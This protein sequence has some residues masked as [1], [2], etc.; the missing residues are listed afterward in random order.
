MGKFYIKT[1]GCQMNVC[2]S[3]KMAGI[4]HSLGYDRAGT[5]EQADVVIVNTCSVRAKPD[6][7][8]Y[9]FIGS[10]RALKKKN[11]AT[12]VAV[13]GCIPQKEG[14]KLLRFSHVDL[15][16]GT[17]NFARL[18]ELIER[19]RRERVV[20]VLSSRLQRRGN[21]PLWTATLKTP[22]LRML[23]CKGVATGFALT[24]SFHTQG[25]RKEA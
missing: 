25:G 17:Y 1:F 4:L 8:A 20:E 13:G 15:V 7:K 16:F 10:L 12:I 21:C 14:R 24:A 5:L 3:Q 18:K 19:A 6:N 2:D 22:M 11:P 23:Q 9:S